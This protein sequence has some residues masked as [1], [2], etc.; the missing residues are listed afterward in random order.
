M[1]YEPD[2]IRQ[3]HAGMVTTRSSSQIGEC[4]ADAD[5]GTPMPMLR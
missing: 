4:V 1:K 5:G 2:R 3:G